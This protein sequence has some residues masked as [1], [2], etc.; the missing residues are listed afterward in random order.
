VPDVYAARTTGTPPVATITCVRS[1]V[2]SA[3]IS[4]TDGSSTTWMTPSGAP[5]ATAA[6]ASVLA[7]SAQHSRASGC[8]LMMTTDRVISASSALK[9]TVAT[10][11]VDGVSASTTPAGRGSSTIFAAGSNRGVT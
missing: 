7:A 5:A 8:G 10:G 1:S 9:N 6:S 4:G 11:L 2:I 3:L